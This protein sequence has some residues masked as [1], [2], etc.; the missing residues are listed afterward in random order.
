MRIVLLGA[1]GCGKGTQG[2]RLAK[3]YKIPEI[4]TGDLLREAVAAGTPLGKAA[5]VVMDAGQLV[6]D[7]IV[8]GVI[9]ERLSRSDARKG[10]ILD[11]F[12]RNLA[13]AEQLDEL[14]GQLSQP[15]D[16]ALLI[17]V[18]VDTIMQRLFGR[19]TCVSCG[20]S[21]NIF[22]APP[23]MDGRCD[24]C[25]GRLRRR[26]DDNE[27]TIGNR[28]RIYELQTLPVV[29]YYR[30]Q[31]IL[32]Q[33]QGTGE[34]D[35]VFQA[36]LKVAEEARKTFPSRDRSAAIRRAVA[37]KLLEQRE[38]DAA[39]VLEEG[40]AR[41]KKAPPEKKPVASKKA[42][43]K[44][45]ASKK[46]TA[47]KK[48]AVAKKAL[49]KKK[50]G[51][52]KAVARKVPAKKKA[53]A[54]KKAVASKKTVTKKLVSKKKTA[55]KKK[56]VAKKKTAVKKKATAKKKTAAKKKAVRKRR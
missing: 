38:G 13:Q 34:P 43:A 41:A 17:D 23:K 21:Y 49:V 29:E 20:A 56:A 53:T 39:P 24:E 10:F 44:K 27:E 51:N 50:V 8:L 2:H 32:R 3:H 28:L 14:L 7:E 15:I 40:K 12:P 31:E 19:R 33:V 16:L 35:D 30:E 55:V 36:V 46:K 4:S 1:P 37:R 11:G 48:K 45:T 25:G 52:K 5:K 42:V 22:Y 6:S 47:V 26:S 18:D 54:K 9:R